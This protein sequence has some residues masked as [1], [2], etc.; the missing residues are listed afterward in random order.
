MLVKIQFD[1]KENNK[2][3]VINKLLD[4]TGLKFEAY[5]AYSN[6]CCFI[7]AP[8]SILPILNN[9]FKVLAESNIVTYYEIGHF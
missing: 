9:V 5:R 1:C 7:Q 6:Y 4:K 3:E 8:S 2:D